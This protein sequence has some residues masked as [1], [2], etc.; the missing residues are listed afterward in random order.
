MAESLDPDQTDHIVHYLPTALS[1]N[2]LFCLFRPDIQIV[3]IKELLSTHLFVCL[4]NDD[5][6]NNN[7]TGQVELS[8]SQVNYYYFKNILVGGACSFIRKPGV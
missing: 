6:N 2:G 1:T 4:N 7:K 5:N 3:C 8:A